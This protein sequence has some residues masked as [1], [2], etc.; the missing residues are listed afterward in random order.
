MMIEESG[1]EACN[2]TRRDKYV[3]I[4]VGKP[5]DRRTLGRPRRKRQNN[6]KT[7]FRL[8][9]YESTDRIYMPQEADP[10]RALVNKVMKLHVA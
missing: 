7:D 2:T 4:S 6:L 5:E 3:K 8:A 1:G 10:R 9:P